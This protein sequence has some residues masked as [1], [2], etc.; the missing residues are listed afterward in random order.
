MKLSIFYVYE[1]QNKPEKLLQNQK[2]SSDRIQVPLIKRHLTE[3]RAKVGAG[4]SARSR[5]RIS[6]SFI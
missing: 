4:S 2:L 6:D 1:K 3:N 5:R